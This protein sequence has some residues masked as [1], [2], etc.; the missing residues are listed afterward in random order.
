MNLKLSE[1]HGLNP[2]ITKCW[3]CGNDIGIVLLGRLPND[4]EAPMSACYGDIC[5][6]CGKDLELADLLIEVKDGTERSNPYRTGYVVG[7]RK[8]IIDANKLYNGI[9]FVEQS[10]LKEILG[11][12]YGVQRN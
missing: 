1:K 11:S 10:M 4:V 5:D 8:G 9:G 12:N 2:S 3:I 7:I 6:K